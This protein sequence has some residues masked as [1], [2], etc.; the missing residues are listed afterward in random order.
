[1]Q[2]YYRFGFS[3]FCLFSAEVT[4]VYTINFGVLWPKI[5]ASVPKIPA[6]NAVLCPLVQKYVVSPEIWPKILSANLWNTAKQEIP[7]KKWLQRSYLKGTYIKS[8]SS[9]RGY[10]SSHF[11]SS[12]IDRE[13]IAL[14]I[15]SSYVSCVFLREKRGDLDLH[16]H[17]SIS[18]LS[19]GNLF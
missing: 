9:T 19:E 7:E 2:I 3:H 18:P 1:M 15:C 11:L 6:F 4:R 5:H 13:V 8:P 17:N 16:F 10:S 12:I 14:Y